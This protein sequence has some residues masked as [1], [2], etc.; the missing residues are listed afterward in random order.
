MFQL[1]FFSSHFTIKKL[2]CVA[3]IYGKVNI[4]TA[5]FHLIKT[6]FICGTTELRIRSQHVAQLFKNSSVWILTIINIWW[7]RN[8]KIFNWYEIINQCRKKNIS[9]KT[10]IDDNLQSRNIRNVVNRIDKRFT[11]WRSQMWRESTAV[12]LNEKETRETPSPCQ[13]TNDHPTSRNRSASFI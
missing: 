11:M 13:N 5:G 4:L 9:S 2:N 1:F 3:N 10:T 12:N 7:N 6:I 8:N